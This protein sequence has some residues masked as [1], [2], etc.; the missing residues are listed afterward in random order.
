MEAT[1]S[2]CLLDGPEGATLGPF[3]RNP[4][5]NPLNRKLLIVFTSEWLLNAGS[6]GCI[7]TCRMAGGGPIRAASEVVKR[8]KTRRRA[9]AVKEEQDTISEEQL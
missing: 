8:T 3:G 6:D 2:L 1:A 7:G 9:L 4:N 5:A